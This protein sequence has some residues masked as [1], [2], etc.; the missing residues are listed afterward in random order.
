[1][2]EEFL[3]LTILQEIQSRKLSSDLILH[4]FK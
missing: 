4:I 2:I 1:M 3:T